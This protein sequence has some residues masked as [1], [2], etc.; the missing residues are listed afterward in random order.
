MRSPP[1]FL[2]FASDG[3]PLLGGAI[4]TENSKFVCRDPPAS[5]T[6]T[7]VVGPDDT[8]IRQHSSNVWECI[9]TGLPLGILF[10]IS[11]CV[12]V[13]NQAVLPMVP[14]V[15]VTTESVARAALDPPA[16]S[17]YDP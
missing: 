17:F 10:S 3:E 11:F 8:W 1:Q 2:H 4:E 9:P 15:T 13:R 12:L 14:S 5:D 7:N 16:L 6:T